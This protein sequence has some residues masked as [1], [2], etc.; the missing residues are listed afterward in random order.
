MPAQLSITTDSIDVSTLTT[1]SI[2]FYW[3]RDNY[4]PTS[5]PGG[6]KLYVDVFD[7]QSYTRVWTGDSDSSGWR[8]AT[9]DI[10]CLTLNND[11]ALRFTVEKQNGTV[12]F[13]TDIIV[14]DI[15]SCSIMF[16]TRQPPS[17]SQKVQVGCTSVG[18]LFT[19]RCHTSTTSS[20]RADLSNKPFDR[21]TR[22]PMHGPVTTPVHRPFRRS[23]P[24]SLQ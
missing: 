10:S 22:R 1:P 4:N 11:I 2:E 3:F 17:P 7:G 21:T 19:C 5:Y 24:Q 13:Y 9:V 8:K 23:I 15:I 12:S 6:N 16:Y 20:R 14:D 18:R